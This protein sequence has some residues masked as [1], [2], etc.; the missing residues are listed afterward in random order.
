M[1][2]CMVMGQCSYEVTTCC[3]WV[4]RWSTLTAGGGR[5]IYLM[6]NIDRCPVR[7]FTIR[8][9]ESCGSRPG[10]R[11]WRKNAKLERAWPIEGFCF[12]VLLLFPWPPDTDTDDRVRCVFAMNTCY[13]LPDGEFESF[14]CCH[15]Q[16]SVTPSHKL[17]SL[18]D[19]PA[20]EKASS[21]LCS[22]RN[23]HART[24]CCSGG[25][26]GVRCAA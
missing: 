2:G 18:R 5:K 16:K 11:E 15:H 4:G 8:L 19:G 10:V 21:T 12:F 6:M 25:E 22:G 1:Y 3:F 14:S 9:R 20:A 26:R 7:R 13:T 24:R 23:H 17:S